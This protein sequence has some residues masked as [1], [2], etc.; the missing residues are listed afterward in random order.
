MQNKNDLFGQAPIGNLLLKQALPAAVGIL[1]L[2]IYGIVDTIFVGRYVGALGIATIT[3]VLPISFLISSIGM[4]IGVGG[5]SIISRSFGDGN[6]KKAYNTFGNQIGMTLTLALLFVGIGYVFAEEILKLFG[7]KGDVL[8]PAK[9][10][11]TIILIGI[12]FMAW[13]MMG[14]NVIRAEGYPRVAMYTLIVPA[15]FNIVLDP[16]F[17]IWFDMGL[18]GAAW[19]T[20]LS[21]MA[22]A[23]Y[24]LWFFVFGKSSMKMGLE[25]FKPNLKISSEIASLGAVTLARQGTVSILA[26]VLNNELFKYGGEQGLST[27]GVINRVMMFANFP[28]LGI[29]Q[30]FVPIAGYNHGAKLRDRVQQSIKLA[31]KSSTLVALLIFILI[32]TFAG[33]IVSIFTED[34]NL[35]SVSVPAMRKSF[36]ATPLLAFSLIGSAYFQAIGKAKP[37]LL[38]AL[39]KQGI[40]LIPLVM[41]MPALFGLEGIWYAFPLADTGAA[42]I[43]YYF[44]R[45]ETKAL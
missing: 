12:P 9:D 41:I 40:F 24:S 16:I 32:L 45:K 21:Y 7:G 34:Q 10:Y 36:L 20:T 11:F 28:V 39:S 22:S 38:L 2:S 15:V 30:G 29:T 1:V 4:S 42:I 44:L 13:A 37:A 23:M 18:K 25:W 5:A 19:A 27:Y 14:N 26:I 31:I 17:I 33:A 6:D 3:V 8:Q 35:I 43:S